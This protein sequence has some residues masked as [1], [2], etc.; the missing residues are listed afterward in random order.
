MSDGQSAA[1]FAAIMDTHQ[2]VFSINT[3]RF[4]GRILLASL[5]LL[6][7]YTALSQ[8]LLFRHVNKFDQQNGLSSSNIRKII[9]DGYGFMWI[10]TQDGLDRFDGQRIVVYN[11]TVSDTDHRT[12]GSDFHDVALDTS[13]NCLWVACSNGLLHLIDLATGKIRNKISLYDEDKTYAAVYQ[14]AVQDK[15]VIAVS[16]KGDVFTV[17]KKTLRVVRR[18][19]LS[20]WFGPQ[21]VIVTRV[22]K[23]PGGRWYF[24][25]N[26]RGLAVFD[27]ALTKP[28]G[29]LDAKTLF[30]TAPLAQGVCNGLSVLQRNRLLVSSLSGFALVDMK[31]L[32]ALP[33]ND[34]FGDAMLYL[35]AKEIYG[36]ALI[37]NNLFFSTSNGFYRFG[38][39]GG[40]LTRIAPSG[41]DRKKNQLDNAYALYGDSTALWI[42]TQDAVN[43]MPWQTP[44]TAYRSSLDESGAS[45]RVCHQMLPLND[46]IIYACAS[47]GLYKTN[48]TTGVIKPLISG[49]PFYQLVKCPNGNILASGEKDLFVLT[50][51]GVKRASSIF[52]E[53]ACI[54]NDFIIAS[55]TYRDSLIF[56]ASQLE[57]GLYIWNVVR[58]TVDTVTLRSP[59]ALKD[60]EINNLLVD[61]DKVGIVCK[62]VY[63]VY[64]VWHRT[65]VHHAVYDPKTNSPVPLLMDAC[66]IGNRYFFAAYGN[67]II[68]TS[69]GFV[70]IQLIAGQSGLTNSGLYKIFPLGDSALLAST[71]DG[72]FCY[73]LRTGTIRRF[74][75]DDGLQSNAFEETSGNRL[76]NTFYFGGF[77]GFTRV[78]GPKL[79]ENPNAPICWI[80]SVTIKHSGGWVEENTNLFERKIVI[81]DDYTQVN[82][83]LSGLLFPRYYAVRYAY[84][85]KELQEEW[86]PLGTQNFINLIGVTHGTYKM[87]VCAYNEDNVPGPVKSILLVF[88]PHWHQTWWFNALIALLVA[89]FL[90]GLYRLRIRQLKREQRIRIKLASDLHD[91]LGST[92]NSANVFTNL[93]L[94]E[95]PTQKYLPKIKEAIG[96]AIV[97]IKDVLWVLDDKKNTVEDL[98]AKIRLFAGVLCEASGIRFEAALAEEVRYSQFKH[99]EKRS[100]YLMLKEAVNNAVKY[101]DAKTIRLSIGGSRTALH[102]SVADDGKGFNKDGAKA[103]NGL[104]NMAWRAEQLKYRLSIQSSHGKG[105]VIVLQKN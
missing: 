97:S 90:Y 88:Q 71:N 94:L 16:N 75:R 81:A 63:S 103:G 96:E 89:A 70:S 28:L 2:V 17:D 58:R 59:A 82:V 40:Q 15:W 68:E 43:V 54:Q 30:P 73:K 72:L 102:L 4:T 37:G 95:G 38:G 26:G 7:V 12:T 60:A 83:N 6:L 42:G 14:L 77:G 52:P 104:K 13:L 44:F 67:G 8:P 84:R 50:S 46:S 45:L 91:D 3:R 78:D 31:S 62:S 74:T 76:G 80:S 25:L 86:Q 79:V 34:F 92:I 105:T 36:T 18:A 64:D 10:A 57:K 101:A 93:A 85:I 69:R 24:F 20:H 47:D 48:L 49:Q 1:G 32:K 41:D 39:S 19:Q 56:L 33:V 5:L 98:F 55:C 29:F 9:R 11:S 21:T 22:T 66:R 99:E 100:L 35:A 53:L 87:E 61:G 65:L 23:A 27:S 51:G